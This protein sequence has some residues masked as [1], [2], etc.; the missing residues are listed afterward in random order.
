M[1]IL[2]LIVCLGL[3]WGL[4]VYYIMVNVKKKIDN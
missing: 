2:W 1:W 4:F 3:N